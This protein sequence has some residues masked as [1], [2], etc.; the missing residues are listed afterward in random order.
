[1]ERTV[2]VTG[3]SSDIGREICIRFAKEGWNVLCH[4]FSSDKEAKDLKKTLVSYGIDCYLLK[5]DL[6]SKSSIKRLLDKIKNFNIQSL[7]NNAGTYTVSK[8]FSRLNIDDITDAFMVNAFAPILLSAGIFMRMKKSGFGRIVNISSIACKYGG[9]SS[10]MHYGCSKLAMEGIA[11]TLS[12]EG[13]AGNVLVNTIRPGVIN[14]KFH[15]RFPKDMKKRITMIPMRKI[16][17]PEDV[18]EMA[19]Y[20]GSDKNN[21]ITGEIITVAGGE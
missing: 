19:Y 8:H 10:S 3:A 2:L 16:G 14:T 11:K 13:A 15:T 12:R 20:V 18:A 6:S 1:M 9:S 7:I 5:A 4:Y 17:N 21:F